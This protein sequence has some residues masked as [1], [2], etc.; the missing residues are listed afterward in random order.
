M[1]D[2]RGREIGSII[3]SGITNMTVRFVPFPGSSVVKRK[4]YEGI[5]VGGDERSGFIYKNVFFH[6]E[7]L[8]YDGDDNLTIFHTKRLH[9]DFFK[10]VKTYTATIPSSCEVAAAWKRNASIK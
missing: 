9:D 8:Y 4:Y 3:R 2:L 6:L 1:I 10:A 7:S 5:S